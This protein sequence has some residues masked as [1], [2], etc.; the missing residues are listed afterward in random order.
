NLIAGTYMEAARRAFVVKGAKVVLAGAAIAATRQ[1]VALA[2]TPSSSG[3]NAAL[4]PTG[5]TSTFAKINGIQMHYVTLGS[6]PIV[7]LLHGW[8]QTWFAWHDVMPRLAKRFTVV[9][10]DLRGNGQTEL[11]DAGYDKRTIAEDLRAL[12]AHL[13]AGRAHVV[14]HDM[15]GKAAYVL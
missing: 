1:S 12:I 15:G 8:P 5:A 13:G 2:Q 14:G 7:L 10:A 3:G 4:L 6:G 11:T 9:A